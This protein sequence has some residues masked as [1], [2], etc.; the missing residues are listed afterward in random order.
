LSV[1]C[2]ELISP[3]RPVKTAAPTVHLF[4]IKVLT[5]RP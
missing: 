1:H 5:G 4:R 2:S 3:M